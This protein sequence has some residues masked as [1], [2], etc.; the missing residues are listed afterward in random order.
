SGARRYRSWE[1]TRTSLFGPQAAGG[2]S[3]EVSPRK[4]G[5]RTPRKRCG[6]STKRTA[7]AR[8][9]AGRG[10]ESGH[11]FRDAPSGAHPVVIIG[12]S[13]GGYVATALTEQRRDLV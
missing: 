5:T 3:G 4:P 2:S 13:S 12:H 8:S 10:V 11:P 6:R 7:L 9:S 1:H